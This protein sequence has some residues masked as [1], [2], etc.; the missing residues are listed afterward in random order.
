MIDHRDADCLHWRELLAVLPPD[1]LSPLDQKALDA[2]L[3]SC[4]TCTSVRDQYRTLSAALRDLSSDAPPPGFPPRLLQLW[5]EKA[6]EPERFTRQGIRKLGGSYVRVHP[7]RMALVG[8]AA[9]V[10]VASVFL[11]PFFAHAPARSPSGGSVV[12]FMFPSPVTFAPSI[13]YEQA[14][15]IITDLG[16]QPALEC[17]LSRL[18]PGAGQ[19]HPQWQPMGQRAA[20]LSNHRLFVTSTYSAPNDWR[21]RLAATPGVQVGASQ[22]SICS[23]VV[24]GTPPPGI[25][26]P[27]TAAQAG[28][29]VRVTFA[30]PINT[31]DAAIYT[32]INT[33]LALADYCYEQGLDKYAKQ[34]QEPVWHP[35]GQ[36]ASF[37]RTHTLIVT[38]TKRVTSSLWLEQLR[39][40]PGVTAIASPYTTPCS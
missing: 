13:S 28:T 23:A 30:Q 35:M 32:V 27:L 40:T 6:E 39:A 38:T 10:L 26:I 22:G 20:F 14:L 8:I 17:G 37:A 18:T 4:P 11:V 29:Y 36:E 19:P 33:G 34:H 16:L 31:Y 25:A 15:R 21:L 1:E 9:A 3:R 24:Y 12:P 7:V 2:H 5:Q